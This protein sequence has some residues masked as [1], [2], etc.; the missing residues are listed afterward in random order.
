[1]NTH[2]EFRAQRHHADLVGAD[3]G[4]AGLLDALVRPELGHAVREEQQDEAAVEE[5]DAEQVRHEVELRVE[6]DDVRDGLGGGDGVGCAFGE[7]WGG[8]PVVVVVEHLDGVPA[9]VQQDVE[10]VE[11]EGAVRDHEG[12]VGPVAHGGRGLADEGSS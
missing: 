1:M 7:A 5:V 12:H 4:L 11:D 3:D 8:D 10:D 2:L 9:A 6:F